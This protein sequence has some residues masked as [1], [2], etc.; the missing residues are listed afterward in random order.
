MLHTFVSYIP[1]ILMVS[2]NLSVLHVYFISCLLKSK[3]GEQ[4]SN[5]EWLNW[6]LSLVWS[7]T[8]NSNMNVQRDLY[9]QNLFL[10]L[11]WWWRWLVVVFDVVVF[12]LWL[13][14]FQYSSGDWP[15]LLLNRM[16]AVRFRVSR[17]FNHANR[18]WISEIYYTNSLA[19]L[20]HT[21]SYVLFNSFIPIGYD[22]AHA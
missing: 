1:P 19:Q 21:Q 9:D 11:Y 5:F 14:T 7:S 8:I 15:F 18:S 22:D 6:C 3:P 17:R 12:D 10:L 16:N 4:A 13:N 20:T 2:I